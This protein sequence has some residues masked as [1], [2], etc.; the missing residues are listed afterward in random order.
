MYY[1]EYLRWFCLQEDVILY[2]YLMTFGLD[3]AAQVMDMLAGFES[4]YYQT[5]DCWGLKTALRANINRGVK[6]MC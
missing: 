3:Q 1:T 4:C 6:S 2:L 5:D